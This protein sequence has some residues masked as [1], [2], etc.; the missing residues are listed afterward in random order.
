[1]W[2]CDGL[3]HCLVLFDASYEIALSDLSWEILVIWIA[4]RNF[5]GYISRYHGRI[6]A[7][8]FDKYSL[9]ALFLGNPGFNFGPVM[10][11]VAKEG[12]E[13]VIPAADFECCW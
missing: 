11:S 10:P 6:I 2:F 3:V 4:R 7:D 12:D 9:N 8:G 1:M 5:E 13:D